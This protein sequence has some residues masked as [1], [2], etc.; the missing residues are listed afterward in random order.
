MLTLFRNA[1]FVSMRTG[2][3]SILVYV[4]C[5]C[6]NKELNFMMLSW[7]VHFML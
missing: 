2:Y 7:L 5:V 6:A 4:I 1:T 3:L